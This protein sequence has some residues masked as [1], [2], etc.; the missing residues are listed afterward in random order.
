MT[1]NAP[2]PTDS[3][4]GKWIILCLLAFAMGNGCQKSV[5]PDPAKQ[6]VGKIVTVQ[7]RRDAL[8]GATTIPVSPFTN[9]INGAETSFTGKVYQVEGNW[10]IVD[11]RDKRVWVPREVVLAVEE[12]I[13]FQD[14]PK[15]P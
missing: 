11:F 13:P 2:T 3:G 1:I 8:G 15:Q 7:F 6:L 14:K 9:V 12:A 10:L 4:N 5:P